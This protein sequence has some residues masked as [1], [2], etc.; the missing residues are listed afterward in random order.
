MSAA[1]VPHASLTTNGLHDDPGA[2]LALFDHVAEVWGWPEEQ[3]VTCL[4]PFLTN[5]A[6]KLPTTNRMYYE[7]LMQAILQRVVHNPEQHHQCF[8]ELLLEEVGQ[9]FAVDRQLQ[10]A[11]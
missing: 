10:D 3:Q 2:F 9:P 4:L 7:Q 1:G 5:E 11:S 8:C 6:E